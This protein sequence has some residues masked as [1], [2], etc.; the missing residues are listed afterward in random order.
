MHGDQPTPVLA[1]AF[2]QGDTANNMHFFFIFF[3]HARKS[4]QVHFTLLV[5]GAITGCSKSHMPH[6]SK[7][8][9]R[10]D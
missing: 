1:S 10:V 6:S 5:C 7:H 2:A 4:A 3:T 8:N 9:A